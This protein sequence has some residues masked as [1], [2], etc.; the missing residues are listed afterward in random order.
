MKTRLNKVTAWLTVLCMLTGM[1]LVVGMPAAV[2]A[3]DTSS[4]PWGGSGTAGDPY[5]ISSVE[6]LIAVSD[7]VYSE[8]WDEHFELG[9][10][11]DLSGIDWTPIGDENTPFTGSFDGDDNTISNLTID[12]DSLDYVGL[13]GYVGSDGIL[14]NIKMQDVEISNSKGDYFSKTVRVGGLAGYSE[15]TIKKSR[16]SNV[17]INNSGAM[18]YIGGL[19]GDNHSGAV[20]NSSSDNVNI[21]SSGDYSYMG[22]LVGSNYPEGSTISGSCSSGSIR[23]E[24]TSI[25]MGGLVGSN[26]YYASITDCYSTCNISAQPSSGRLPV[27]GLVGQGFNATITNSY[28]TGE[29]K[30]EGIVYVGG[31]IGDNDKYNPVTITSSYYD[32]TVNPHIAGDAGDG[33]PKTTAELQQMETFAGW[34]FTNTWKME[35]GNGYPRLQWQ[36]PWTVDEEITAARLAL[37]WDS[38]KGENDG[39]NNVKANL[40]NPLPSEGTHGT[41]IEW[42]VSDDRWIDTVTGEVTRPNSAEGD[43]T[44]ELT[45]TIS[46]GGGTSQTKVFNLTI[47]VL[48][49]DEEA[50]ALD[51]DA[52]TWNS[53]KGENGEESRV[54]EDLV[55]PLPT[56]GANGAAII[57][58]ASP[59][60]WIDTATGAVT[61]PD[62]SE[63]NKNV[64]LTATVS[65]GSAESRE[66]VFNLTIVAAVTWNG[67]GSSEN[68]YEVESALHLDDVRNKML[69]NEGDVCFIQIKD[70]DLSGFIIWTP[71]GGLPGL[72]EDEYITFEGSY[73]GNG[74]KISNLTIDN[75]TLKYGGLFG[76]VGEEGILDNINLE[77]VNIGSSK[78][79]AAIGGLAGC[80]DGTVSSCSSMG[81][82][83]SEDGAAVGGLVGENYGTVRDSFSS[84]SVT[85]N[86]EEVGI[87]GLMAINYG[88]VTGSYSTG[89]VTVSGDFTLSGGLAGANI[90]IVCDSY[91]GSSVTCSAQGVAIT[92][93]FVGINGGEVSCSYSYGSVTR[94]GDSIYEGGL[95]GYN[96][97]GVVVEYSYY[98]SEA[99]L[100]NDDDGR[101]EPRST[102][103][104]MQKDT[105]EGWNFN[106]MW[107][108]F[109]NSTYPT[110]RWQTLT[111]EEINAMISLD[112]EAL[113]WESIK[114]T[115][116]T[117]DNVT[118]NLNLPTTGA[119]GSTISWSSSDISAVANDGAVVRPI[120]GDKFVTLT[121]A[122]SWEGG[123]SQTKSFTL[124]VKMNALASIAI[125]TPADKLTYIVG[126]ELDISGMVITGTYSDG[127]TAILP[128]TAAN[129]SG[130]DSSA[131]VASQT[132]TVTVEGKTAVYTI[133]IN[134]PSSNGGNGGSG[135]RG[136][137]TP[138]RKPGTEQSVDS[139]GK[140]TAATN[141]DKTTGVAKVN[142]NS[143][144]LEEAF[145]KASESSDGTVEIEMPTVEEARAYEPTLPAAILSSSDAGT[146][147]EIKTNIAA[148]T[149]PGNMLTGVDAANFQD[150]SLTIARADLSNIADEETR[151]RIGDRPVIQLGLKLDGEPYAW[152]NEN[153][154]V[155]VSIP[156]TPI[157]EELENPEHITI[158]YIDNSGNV[159]E[160]P[161]GRYDSATGTVIF[162]TTHF[163][164]YAVAY[165]MKTFDDLGSATWAR[166]A[167]EVLASKGILKGISKK[168]YAPQT[169]ITRADFL[170]FL[171]RTLGV[172]A[173]VEGNFDDISSGAYYYK[174]ISIAKK[175]G[176]TN[177]V[178]SN[179]F[180][181]DAS[182]TR[183]DMM[184]LT[185]RALRMQKKL[186]VQGTPA[187]LEKFTDKSLI[188]D[189]AADAVAAIVKEGLIVGSGDSIN[190]LD[191]TTRA[192]TAVFLYRIY[193]K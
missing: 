32:S 40:I 103:E 189:Y 46:K 87:G 129:I 29:V 174:E 26:S 180:N 59:A 81:S 95:I 54:T 10:A 84:G 131:A 56:E 99:S 165:V 30:Q 124:I 77:N 107:R 36:L 35:D 144:I 178:G 68:P 161:S 177:G 104:M 153:A 112:K 72:P 16:I 85:G 79:G 18:A 21:N 43:E 126:D 60:G 120:D 141:L 111:I 186:E 34:D 109:E 173:K 119:N 159:V 163:S 41:A 137:G 66:V 3:E 65:K 170:Y 83:S 11:I 115:N 108:I 55:N 113:T 9:T 150:V 184:V 139:S 166:K 12:N 151:N 176:I 44:V 48:F 193:N 106:N 6:D 27:G 20:I 37:T 69:E 149:L 82:V 142:I 38:I 191:N 130:F 175:L 61:I 74:K 49:T 15:G 114:G 71:I 152:S 140:V 63:G 51:A 90:G 118:E 162:S 125:T 25:T 47:K 2:Y 39:E 53:I 183:Q 155:T 134:R 101:G 181:P 89:S 17:D 31:L 58:I 23:A 148:V 122:V 132:L 28:C 154:P 73:N 172:D 88:T 78:R 19:V 22:G 76:Y 121:A 147:L 117:E 96:Y 185:E 91:S 158:W 67:D 128:I 24:D 188:T 164:N 94:N 14:E 146:R 156:Y 42:S 133:T 64:T 116:L 157:A 136:G 80:S 171:V 98:D 4:A 167:V 97:D 75:D 135:G 127:S 138:A 7:A 192:E 179:K 33:T 45:A 86:G 187:D 143:G 168:E 52:L 105:F 62:I 160:V 92:G 100:Q 110:L 169:N 145:E 182:I 93:G 5:V 190:P 102:E 1:F 8:H 70:I 123:T 50:V 13:F 57:W